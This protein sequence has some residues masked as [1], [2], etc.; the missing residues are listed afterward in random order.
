MPSEYV[1]SIESEEFLWSNETPGSEEPLRSEES[2]GFEMSIE[3][4]E[5]IGYIEYV[6]SSESIVS[7]MDFLNMVRNFGVEDIG[8][9][10][11]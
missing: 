3:P 9:E 4:N 2:L 8:S 5:S 10:K 7:Q 11:F 6:N 1:D